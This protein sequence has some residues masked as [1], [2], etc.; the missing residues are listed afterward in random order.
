MKIFFLKKL[1]YVESSPIIVIAV[2][3]IQVIHDG[4]DKLLAVSVV[5][6]KKECFLRAVVF[7]MNR[8]VSFLLLENRY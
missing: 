6:S 1:Y 2:T 8:T 5:Q 7:K 4:E 3:V